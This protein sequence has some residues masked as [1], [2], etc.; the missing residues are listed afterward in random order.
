MKTTAVVGEKGQVTIPK[1]LRRSLGITPGTE[2][3]FEERHGQL[4]AT[5]VAAP[6][7]LDGVVGILPRMDVDAALAEMRGPAW[8]PKL[9]GKR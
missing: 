1:P 2:L 4:V 9:D 6:G 8:N 5:R 7:A 3:R